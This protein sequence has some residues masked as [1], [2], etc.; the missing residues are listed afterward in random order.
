MTR[1]LLF[2]LL[3]L[4][5]ALAAGTRGPAESALAFLQ[6]LQEEGS[7]P[8]ID[9]AELTALFPG[10]TRDRRA[11]IEG[12]LLDLA[13]H[14][15]G[16]ELE[17]LESRT[18]SRL[19]AVLVAS[20]FGLNTP[21]A[22]VHAI[23]LIQQEGE[24]RPAP[25]PASFANLGI[26]YLPDLAQPMKQLG[27]WMK[28]EILPRTATLR[29]ALDQR[30]H[31]E[32]LSS[33]IAQQT[34]D[35]VSL[36]VAFRDAIATHDLPTLLACL[37]GLEDPLPPNFEA[38]LSFL[39]EHL[40]RLPEGAPVAPQIFIPIEQETQD[41]HAILT[42]AEFDCL[43]TRRGSEA[44]HIYTFDLSQGASGRWHLDAS[45]E[46]VF[47][48][49]AIPTPD[50]HARFLRALRQDLSS[51][52]TATPAELMQRT[53]AAIAETQPTPY[54]Q[55]FS[56]PEN[57]D[58]D[59]LAGLFRPF[60]RGVTLHRHP[61]LLE[62]HEIGDRAAALVAEVDLDHP[63]LESRNLSAYHLRHTS[64]GWLIDP[65]PPLD[66]AEN[67]LHDWVKER[68]QNSPEDWLKV[69]GLAQLP[70]AA[71]AG[72]VELSEARTVAQAWVE[73]LGH[74]DLPA[75]LQYATAPAGTASTRSLLDYLGTE[76]ASH[77]ELTL[78]EVHQAGPWTAA[79]VR[80]QPAS[81]DQPATYLLHPIVP[82]PEGPRVLPEAILYSEDTRARQLLN[83]LARKR[84]S[85]A[86]PNT[87]SGDLEPLLH[88]HE[89]LARTDRAQP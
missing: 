62:I 26:D 40:D 69:L 10:T 89:E 59:T 35:P 36:V 15:E 43:K 8:A 50:N 73:A 48:R 78:L 19:A 29:A 79:T 31:Q 58:A 52:P 46:I 68:S 67:P 34:P 42:F 25:V 23:G 47:P 77:C 22:R 83:D 74:R 82:G 41:Q 75:A 7:K 5:A 3:T 11:E 55:Q 17:I 76:F 49:R 1:A 18:D 66:P 60:T 6:K 65:A 4:P 51:Q 86:F 37:G 20:T 85:K 16:A 27:A 63:D 71:Q 21:A 64:D 88:H 2:L 81:P 84:L 56:L 28:S 30:L 53:F 80:H 70:P 61:I 38:T 9:A 39:G 44:L 14:L 12:Q 72:P 32:I 54:L 87:P 33:E 24:W 45:P 57:L 13:S